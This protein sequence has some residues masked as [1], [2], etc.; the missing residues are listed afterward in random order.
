MT[1][2]VDWVVNSN[3]IV[4]PMLSTNLSLFD[5]TISART[6]LPVIPAAAAGKFWRLYA[7]R[8]AIFLANDEQGDS[9]VWANLVVPT[10]VALA[11]MRVDH[12]H[13]VDAQIYPQGLDCPFAAAVVMN[14]A[15]EWANTTVSLNVSYSLIG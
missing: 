3:L 14:G 13:P 4:G 2:S 5:M 15:A 6:N 12:D 1:D 10:N 11:L 8:L 7:V 9:G